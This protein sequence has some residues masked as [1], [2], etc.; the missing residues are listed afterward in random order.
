MLWLC[1]YVVC[2]Q[3]NA[4]SSGKTALHCAVA[5]GKMNVA[6]ALLELGANIECE[7]EEGLK[8]LHHCAL[9]EQSEI[10]SFLLNAGCDP[11]SKTNSE[12]TPLILAAIKGSTKVLGILLKWPT[13]SLSEMDKDGDTALHCAV[14]GR[15]YQALCALLEAGADPSL[16]NFNILTP[17]HLAVRVGFLPAV[18]SMVKSHPE[19]V[20]V[21]DQVQ[22]TP[23][24]VAATEGEFEVARTLL[25]V[26]ECL[27]DAVTETGHT[28]LHGAIMKDQSKMVE[29]LI[30]YGADPSITDGAGTTP[31]H[32]A[33]G[34]EDLEPPSDCTPELNKVRELLAGMQAGEVSGQLVVACFLVREEAD[35]RLHSSDGES[36]L[37][38]CSPEMA[39]TVS[40]FAEKYAGTGTY[41]GSLRQQK[42]AKNTEDHTAK[43]NENV[44][45]EAE[46]KWDPEAADRI[47]GGQQMSLQPTPNHPLT[48]DTTPSSTGK[49]DGVKTSATLPPQTSPNLSTAGAVDLCFLCDTPITVRFEPC[50]HSPLCQNCA[51][52]ARKCPDCKTPVQAVSQIPV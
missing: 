32:R 3:V 30:G 6:E 46:S 42:Q 12:Q 43:V 48:P 31:V 34:N 40:S 45:T 9:R 35:L 21:R 47:K 28:P 22:C 8:P 11:N 39:V 52:R 4:R 24:H 15:R 18:E 5:A 25:E 51:R 26:A 1:T 7:D 41:R 44:S 38:S 17:I 16:I 37:D 23:L 29:L 49:P 14:H 2:V 20:N 50:G 27:V 13:T 33:L 36:P 10:A 19:H